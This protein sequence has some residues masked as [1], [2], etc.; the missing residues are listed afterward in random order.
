MYELSMSK[1]F[2][3][4]SKKFEYANYNLVYELVLSIFRS[5]I[6]LVCYLFI[7]DLKIMIYLSVGVILIGLFLKFRPLKGEDFKVE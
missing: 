5:L 6:L 4:L 1:E 3:S 2:Y 7:K